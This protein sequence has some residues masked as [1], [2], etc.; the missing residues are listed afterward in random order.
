MMRKLSFLM[1]LLMATAVSAADADWSRVDQV[2]GRKG[3]E[4]PG[5]IHRYGFPRSDLEVTLDGVTIKPSFAL[6]GWAAFEPIGSETMLMGDFVLTDTEINPV[7]K[8]AL[9]EGLEITAIHNHLLRTS[10]PVFYMH[11]GGHGDPVKLSE[12]LRAA[13]ALSKTPLSQSP[14]SDPPPA[15]DLD[16]AA[17]EKSLG[18][19]GKNNGG[20]YQFGIPRAE[21]I[22]EGGM[23]VPPSMGTA[24]AIN[25]QPTGHGKAAITGDFVLVGS[26]VQPVLKALRQ[27]GIEVTALHSHMVDE[28]PRLYF[29]H[30]WA[31]ED[32][33]KLAGGLRA[34]LD[35]MNLKRAP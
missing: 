2:L 34:A 21:T 8:K 10:V 9:E 11:V 20:V 22:T 29:T 30:F 27:H 14:P 25:F 16:T 1:T 26:E 15:I 33:Q 12:S 6:G 3:A 24:T 31:N 23:T 13:L 28:N 18:A 32:A 35:L 7:M 17:I 5:G 19:K 4:Q